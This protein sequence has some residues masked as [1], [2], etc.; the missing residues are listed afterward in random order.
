MLAPPLMGDGPTRRRQSPCQPWPERGPATPLSFSSALTDLGPASENPIEV[1]MR[2]PPRRYRPEAEGPF[3]G[4]PSRAAHHG[5]GLSR[6]VTTKSVRSVRHCEQ[7]NRSC[8][9]RCNAASRGAADW[10]HAGISR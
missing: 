2:R 1:A 10:R 3:P 7:R 4:P 6:E 9:S 5:C 8:P